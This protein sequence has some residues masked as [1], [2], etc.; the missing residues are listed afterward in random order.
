MA[1]PFA[2]KLAGFGDYTTPKSNFE[3]NS[4]F[5]N[6]NY[7]FEKSPFIFQHREFICDIISGQPGTFDYQTW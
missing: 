2:S 1:L 7:S 6:G 4:L 3:Q 5:K